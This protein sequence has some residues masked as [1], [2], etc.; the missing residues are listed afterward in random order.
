MCSPEVYVP[1]PFES[2]KFSAQMALSFFQSL[3]GH[4]LQVH[5]AEGGQQCRCVHT[6]GLKDGNGPACG[7]A[8]WGVHC[9]RGWEMELGCAG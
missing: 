4:L 5:S 1:F 8:V 9:H 2:L 6:P 3:L 7:A